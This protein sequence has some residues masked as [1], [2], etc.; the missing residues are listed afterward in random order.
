[1][2]AFKFVRL[3]IINFSG[4]VGAEFSLSAAEEGGARTVLHF[5]LD[6]GER[7][8]LSQG[9]LFSKTSQTHSVLQQSLT[10]TPEKSVITE[11]IPPQLLLLAFLWSA[12]SANGR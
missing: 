6:L 3:N 12:G 11:I 4:R 10:I 5:Q 7:R 1:M 9:F 8:R 2:L